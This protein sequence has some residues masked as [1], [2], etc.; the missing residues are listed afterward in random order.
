MTFLNPAFLFGLL[1]A[2]IPILIH[3]LNLRKLQRVDFSTLKFIKELQKNQIRKIKLRQ[4]ILLALRV[5]FILFLV[6]AFSRPAL[7]GVAIAGVTSSA[8]TGTV[9]ILDNSP[10]MEVI[11]TDGSLFNKAKSA[12]LSLLNTMQEGDEA[13]LITTTANNPSLFLSKN[14]SE[15]KKAVRDLQLSGMKGRIQDALLLAVPLLESSANFNKEI[16]IFSDFQSA[17]LPE[18]KDIVNLSPMLNERMHIYLMPVH[19]QGIYNAGIDELRI[20]SEIFEPGKNISVTTVVTNYSTSR[21]G[22]FILSLYAG[23]GRVAQKSIAVNALASV[24]A[25]FEIPLPA[26]GYTTISAVLEDDDILADNNRYE[27]IYSPD[28]MNILLL[29]D[30]PA[31][32]L[33][34]KTALETAFEGKSF[35][36]TSRASSSAA[37]IDYSQYN[38]V[39]LVTGFTPVPVESLVE[40]IQ[41]GKGGLCV[42]PSSAARPDVLSETLK[43]LSLPPAG[44]LAGSPGFN[45][46]PVRF[47]KVYMEHQ[48]FTGI[49]EKNKTAANSPDIYAYYQIFAPAAGKP[50]ITLADNSSFLSEYKLEAGKI[51]LFSVPPDLQYSTLP[52]TGLFVPLVY[53]SAYYLAGSNAKEPSLITGTEL[54]MHTGNI[55]K[56]ILKIALPGG[57][58]EFVDDTRLSSSYLSIKP[59]QDPGIYTLLGGSSI[60]KKSAVNIS[61]QES[62]AERYDDDF[63]TE[64]FVKTGA[65]NA[66]VFIPY[67]SDISES[68]Q[69]A[70]FGTEL[71]KFFLILALITGLTEMAVARVSSKDLTPESV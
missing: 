69:Q 63:L 66:P 4:W 47:D 24:S 64:Y 38:A 49:F 53:R 32:A 57:K 27:V 35:S 2:G 68:V 43:R 59:V 50:I 7:K 21:Q 18:E 17:S 23:E 54:L 14:I 26:G 58:E 22:S 52:L 36:V 8:K 60:L 34:L 11:D 71:W 9:I 5:L 55:K 13:V 16:F 25:D 56:D 61:P 12:A 6:T 10:S 28:K 45:K 30:T 29:Y 39:F 41:S 19:K 67:S 15:V 51:L 44:I 48:L 42:F 20:N 62:G 31:D 65:A 46:S 1:A 70:R 3:L 40:Y 33:F 37:G